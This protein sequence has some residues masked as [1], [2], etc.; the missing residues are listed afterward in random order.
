[1]IPNGD[2]D[3][4][5]LGFIGYK[6]SSMPDKKTEGATTEDTSLP[7]ERG[8]ALFSVED[9]DF[10]FVKTLERRG[11]G[12]LLFLARRKRRNELGGLVVVKRL[13]SPSTFVRR[14]RL[15]EEVQL[16][17]RLH[18]PAI[19]QV[20]QL[21]IQH[22]MPH[23]IMEHVEGPSLDDL[24]NL[25]VMRGK[26]L[27][28]EFGLYVGAEL[29]DA[30]HHAH[31]LKDDAGRELRVIHRDVSPRNIRVDVKT[32][33]V[34]LSDFGAAY[35]LLIGREESP[36]SLLKGDVAYASPEYLHR[37]RLD[38][39]SDLFSLGLVLVELLTSRHLF[40]VDAA[41]RIAPPE[42]LPD[43]RAE[44][45][46]SLPLTQMKALI[47]RYGPADV[48]RAVARLSEPVK[49]ILHRALMRAPAERFASAVEMRDALRAVLAT[50]RQPYGRQEAAEEL[51]LLPSEASVMRDKV[52]CPKTS[53]QR[54]STRTS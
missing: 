50:K 30:L 15:V 37:G 16:A 53:S 38:A 39:R 11:I 28:E 17:I 52:G 6:G 24:V 43:V 10:E 3:Y 25:A 4:T 31:T 20:H 12:E 36:A 5:S 7:V 13:R 18:H 21:T 42:G 32:G 49:A 9:T 45:D 51:G 46:P 14:Q 44:E 34:K 1:M 19:A 23:L 2:V 22:G 8:Q 40:D 29:A 26:P 41:R 48:E 27:S 54:A 35:S 33:A 47:S